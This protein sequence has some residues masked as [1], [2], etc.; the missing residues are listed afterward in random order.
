MQVVEASAIIPLDLE[1][2]W[3]MLF[4]DQ[5]QRVV[6]LLDGVVAVEDYQMRADGTPRYR[7]ARKVGPFTTRAT[8]D[9]SVYGRPYQSVSQALDKPF[10]GTFDTTHEPVA[11][12]TRLSF[13]WEL[14]PQNSLV[15]LLLPVMRPL[16]VRQLQQ[17]LDDLA[18]AATPKGTSSARRRG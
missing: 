18:K 10:G 15:G 6:K 4:G 9:Y 2:T 16:L 12:G 7:M 3:D 17:D 1:E 14:E 11:G 13:R 8:S 5:M